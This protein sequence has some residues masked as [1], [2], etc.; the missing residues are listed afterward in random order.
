VLAME[1]QKFN[2][3]T[4]LAIALTGIVVSALAAGLLTDYQRIPNQGQVKAVGVGVYW[5]E[6]CTDNVTIIDWGLL[7]PGDTAT[8]EVW[9][10]NIGNTPI[11]LNMTTENWNDP[12]ARNYITLTWDCERKVL[13][14][15]RTVKAVLTLSI[16]STI[17]ETDIVEFSFYIKIT[18]TEQTS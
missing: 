5:N 11:M 8:K 15:T 9:I 17:T 14:A 7:G 10:K 16:S 18:G 4:I 13:N 2:M 12:E 6:A 3:A 1:T